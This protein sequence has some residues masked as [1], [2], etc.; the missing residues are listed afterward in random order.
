MEHI[1]AAPAL[2]AARG[3]WNFFSSLWMVVCAAE[4]ESC[5]CGNL[6]SATP[7]PHALYGAIS[8]RIL[9]GARPSFHFKFLSIQ[10]FDT[11]GIISFAGH[12]MTMILEHGCVPAL[13]PAAQGTSGCI[14]VTLCSCKFGLGVTC[15]HL[16]VLRDSL[17]THLEVSNSLAD[18][19]SELDGRA[20]PT[21]SPVA[22]PLQVLQIGQPTER[23]STCLINQPLLFAHLCRLEISFDDTSQLYSAYSILR[24]LKSLDHLQL[25]CTAVDR[26]YLPMH[27]PLRNL[28]T[29]E[30]TLALPPA[31]ILL[32]LGAA[33]AC[34]LNTKPGLSFSS[35]L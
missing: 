28:R 32:R 20:I 5:I 7:A 11:Y 15:G 13:R 3:P 22:F 30:L 18:V 14:Y 17:V 12:V 8:A 1:Y 4:S 25:Q 35:A 19:D 31:S 24:A 6:K 23:L 33:R 9:W 10:L 2:S 27:W 34:A 21:R 26:I 29:V 16:E